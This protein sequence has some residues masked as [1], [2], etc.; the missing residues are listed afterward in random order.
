MNRISRGD[1]Q[2]YSDSD[3]EES[4]TGSTTEADVLSERPVRICAAVWSQGSTLPSSDLQLS[5]IPAHKRAERLS[6]ESKLG[7]KPET[8]PEET[9]NDDSSRSPGQVVSLLLLF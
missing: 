7:I 5:I 2:K 9:V 4:Q 1:K 8:V 3:F 6:S